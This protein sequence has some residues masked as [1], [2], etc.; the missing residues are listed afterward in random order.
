MIGPANAT[1]Q[2]NCATEI[3]FAEAFKRAEFLDDYL[4]KYGKPY[5]PFHGLPISVKVSLRF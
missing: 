5:G 1:N 2:T 3:L 4:A